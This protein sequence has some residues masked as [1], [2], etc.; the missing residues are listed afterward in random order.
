MWPDS[1]VLPVAKGLEKDNKLLETLHLAPKK[2]SFQ[3]LLEILKQ[4][5]HK[6]AVNGS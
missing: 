2:R 3:I 1:G 4:T 6:I 5:I